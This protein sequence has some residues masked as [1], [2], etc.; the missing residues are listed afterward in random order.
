VKLFD[1]VALTRDL[2]DKGLRRGDVAT[3]VEFVK[4]RGEAQAC[5][6]EVFNAL[7]DTVAVVTVERDA[8]EPLSADEVLSVRRLDEPVATR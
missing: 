2:P 1:Q 7:G 6:V 5:V 4:G 3:L 8:L